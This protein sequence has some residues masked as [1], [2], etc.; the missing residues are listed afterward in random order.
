MGLESV[1]TNEKRGLMRHLRQFSNCIFLSAV[2][3]GILFPQTAIANLLSNPGFESGGTSPNSWSYYGNGSST[4]RKDYSHT[5]SRCMELG[6]SSFK[7]V[8]QQVA[9]TAGSIYQARAWAQSASGTNATLKLEFRDAG[10]NHIQDT[11]SFIAS[12]NWTEYSVTNIAPAWATSVTASVVGDGPGTVYF[13]DVTIE[14][15][16][17]SPDAVTFDLSDTSHEFLGFGAHVWGYGNTPE[18]PN[19]LSYRQQALSELNIKYIRIENYAES[20]TWADMQATRA[21]TDALG[22]EWVYMVWIGPWDYMDGN[23]MLNDVSGFATWWTSHV[24]DLYNHSIPVEYIELMNEPDSWGQWSTGIT[25]SDYNLLVKDLRSKLDAAGY[26]NVGIVGAGPASMD[27]CDDYINALDAT[28]IAA[29]DAWSAHSWGSLDGPGT[30][31]RMRSSMTIPGDAADSTLPKF[32]TEYATH[33]TNFHGVSSPPGDDY[34]SWNDSNVFPYYATANR[35]PFGV[36]TYANTLGLLNGGAN[37]PFIW[38]LID[39]PTETINK[40]KNWGGLDLWGNPKPVY[41]ALKTLYPKIPIGS[42]VATA[43]SQGTNVTYAGTFSYNNRIVIGIAN[44]LS[45]TRDNTI[46]LTNAPE[47]L[48]IVEGVGFEPLSWGDP[49]NGEPDVGQEVIRGDLVLNT[50]SP[51]SYSIDASLPGDS[52]LTVILTVKPDLNAD[53]TVDDQDIVTL[54]SNW[55]QGGSAADIAPDGGDGTVNLLDFALFAKHWLN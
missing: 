48:T 41:G 53:G 40:T 8:H 54:L 29:M 55:L 27:V 22:I 23:G 26:S 1:N 44:E 9:G 10:S 12:G 42:M 6:G 37:S 14:E 18:Y 43:P 52:T 30:E 16:T 11:L 15:I 33:E 3:V 19:L 24:A 5:G 13:D 25:Y 49:S 32:V 45:T 4:Y 47:D 35:V 17:A 20:A 21:I 50:I 51:T 34:G 46:T 36:R 7:M 38:Q 28:G 31:T 2:V 39:E